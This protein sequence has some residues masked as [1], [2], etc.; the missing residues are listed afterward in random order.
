MI[1][2]RELEALALLRRATTDTG[3][4]AHMIEPNRKL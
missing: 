1:V 2:D 4:V 3:S